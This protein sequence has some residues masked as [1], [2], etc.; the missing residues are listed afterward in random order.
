MADTADLAVH[1]APRTIYLK[2]YIAPAYLV[3]VV[4]LH[5]DLDEE[6]TVVRSRLVM[7]RNEAARVRECREECGSEVDVVGILDVTHHRYP[8]KDVLLLFYRCA[9]RSG[10]VQHLQ[11][12]DHAW[13]APDELDA[14][15]LPPADI[16]VVERIRALGL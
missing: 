13:V 4:D 7:R 5:F 6:A 3:D 14:Y 10:E 16:G 12:A 1:D 9:L 11:V 8:E 2:D 15:A